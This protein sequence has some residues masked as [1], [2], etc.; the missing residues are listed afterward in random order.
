MADQDTRYRSVSAA[1]LGAESARR[2]VLATLGQRPGLVVH[3][4][5]ADRISV[6]R[7]RRPRWALVACALTV[8]LGGLGLLFLLV[9][10]TEAGEVIVRD[11]PR[12][13]TVAVPPLLDAAAMHDLEVAL[14]V[15]VTNPT[16]GSHPAPTPDD[17]LDGRTVARRD[18]TAPQST[19]R[20]LELRFA[21][22]VI[23]LQAGEV[24]V[25]GRD[26][27]AT[28]AANPYVVPGD[29]GSVSKSHLLVRFD[30]A[31]ATAEDLGS[32]N[33]STIVR[34]GRSTALPAGSPAP[35][36]PG[37]QV[38]LGDLTCTVSTSVIS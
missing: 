14:S 24:G 26:P 6:A 5:S 25:L 29:A 27:S 34:D 18:D 13:C 11:G 38:V 23:T 30:G 37:D 3:E 1:G 20:A 21:A 8:W 7:T 35:L 9:T 22:G 28:G 17:G 32:T 16:S 2:I 15:G 19:R 31:T 33:G 12:G 4:L 36:R 10:H